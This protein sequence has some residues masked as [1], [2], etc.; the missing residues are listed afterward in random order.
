MQ[1]RSRFSDLLFIVGLLL[2]LLIAGCAAEVGPAGPQGPEGPQGPPGPAGREGPPGP[3]GPAGQDGLSYELPTFVGSAACGECH[4][5]IYETF[6]RSGHPWKLTPVVDGEPPDYP[7]TEI[8]APPENYTWDEISYVIGGYNWKARFIDQ[9]GYIITGE[10]ENAT[11]QY[12]F[13]NEE[14][15]LGG[16]WV[17]YHAG[18]EN[19]P[20]TCGECHTTGY[21]PRGN[22]DGRPG[23]IGTWAEG[24]IQCEE[25]HGPGSQHAN[26]PLAYEM[27]I[28]RD[29]ESCGACHVRGPFEEVDASG[30]FIR[31]HE[32]YE[33]LFQS[34]HIALDC[35]T[36]H[37]PHAGV[38]QL[39]E[40]GQQTVRTT[41]ENCHFEVARYQNNEV[42]EDI[43]VECIDCHMPRIVKSAVG[44]PEAFTG[45]IRSHIMAI[46]PYQVGQ[47]T[48][49]GTQAYSQIALDFACRS[50]HRPDGRGRPKTD[51][52]L[53]QTAVNY[54]APPTAE[55]EPTAESE[56]PAEETESP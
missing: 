35:V 56:T 55:T 23:L 1:H 15:D 27:N 38:V 2:A 16:D 49:D 41:C 11:T 47:F 8:P 54:H 28:D 52:E 46:D 29:A 4:G 50:C 32:Q 39:R 51:E 17:G 21:T 7:F 53:L 10:D 26:H 36:C 48:E 34:K 12:N 19:L 9:D 33:E 13:Y 44:D 42:H 5:D 20:Y 22:Q 31:H 6:Q 3:P 37:D 30:G 25:C 24:G 40:A 14:V 45:D 43:N 18:E